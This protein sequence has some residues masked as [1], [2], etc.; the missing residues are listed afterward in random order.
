MNPRDA[1]AEVKADLGGVDAAGDGSGGLGS[2]SG[3]EGNVAFAGKQSG[4]GVETNPAGT[5]EED[6]GPGVEIR[7]IAGRS[8][9]A[10]ERLLVGGELDEVAGDEACGKSEAAEQVDEQPCGVAAGA[11][12]FLQRL[13]WSLD[14]GFEPDGVTDSLL[15]ELVEADEKV[16]GAAGTAIDGLAELQEFRGIGP[17]VQERFEVLSE[18]FGVAER[19]ISGFAFEEEIEGIDDGHVSDDVNGDDEV[20]GF[21]WEDESGEVIAERVLLP[22]DEVTGRFD[23]ERPGVDWS[24]TVWGW[25]EPNYLRAETDQPVVVIGSL[26]EQ[27]DFDGHI[28]MRGGRTPGSEFALRTRAVGPLGAGAVWGEPLGTQSISGLGLGLVGGQEADAIFAVK[29]PGARDQMLANSG[30]E[31]NLP[32]KKA[33][34]DDSRA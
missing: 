25:S 3:G 19:E 30:E 14:P 34:E 21:L 5:G 27:S 33:H 31:G 16:D 13:R 1:H 12:A 29:L 9:G 4:G 11:A 10:F 32:T 6:L 22:V 2:G 17:G 15:N 18:F 26:M 20:V 23:F 8:G 28:G 24:A 7:E